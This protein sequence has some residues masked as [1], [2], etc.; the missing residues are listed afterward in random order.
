MRSLLPTDP[1]PSHGSVLL[2][3]GPTGTAWQRHHNDGRWHSTSGRSLTWDE[4]LARVASRRGALPLLLVHEVEAFPPTVGP[5]PH[6][7]QV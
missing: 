6:T 7:V 1:E 4:L 2:S 5:P 3:E